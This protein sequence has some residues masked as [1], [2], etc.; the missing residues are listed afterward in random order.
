MVSPEQT[1]INNIIQIEVVVQMYLEIH[2][3]IKCKQYTHV[4]TIN[5]KEDMNLKERRK[6]YMKCLEVRK[7]RMEIIQLC[8]SIRIS[9]SMRSFIYIYINTNK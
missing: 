6:G 1:H 2:M 9:K 3:D 5:K 8:N 4:M 7:G